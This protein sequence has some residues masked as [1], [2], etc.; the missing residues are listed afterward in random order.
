M[1]LIDNRKLQTAAIAALLFYIVS[2]PLTYSIVDG[3]LG[4][5]FKIAD[6]TGCP[7]G[8]GLIVH[9]IV[10]GLVSYVIMIAY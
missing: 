6:P 2:S 4:G 9:T 5:F 7:T 10:Y 3:L 1:R 8:T